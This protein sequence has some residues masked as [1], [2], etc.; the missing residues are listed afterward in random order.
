MKK[1]SE[2]ILFFGNERLATGVTTDA[3]VL[4]ALIEAGYKITAVVASHEDP[5][6]RTRRGLEIGTLAHSYDIPVLLPGKSMPLKEKLKGHE[7]EVAV[8]VAFGK[9][10]PQEV[11]DAFPRGIINI[12]PSLLPKHRGPT[13]I[14]SVILGGEALTGVSIMKLGR[15]MDAGP[16]YGQSEVNLKGNESKQQLANTLLEVGKSMLLELLPGILEGSI[17][18]VP[19]DNKAATY[20]K[21]IFKQDGV[22]DW[23]KPATRLEREVR[24]YMEWPKSRAT[25][26]GKE[27]VITKAKVAAESGQ[28]GKIKVDGKRLIVFCGEQALEILELKP[29]GKPAMSAQAFLAGYRAKM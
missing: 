13:P 4:R 7:A 27:V 29:S 8:L 1:M 18:A 28:P 24:A 11:V 20:D 19:Q 26:A 17:V 14:E 5:V 9:I 22:I 3:P 23:R 21:L 6:S 10:V 2:T 15:V 25:L 16:I 12:H